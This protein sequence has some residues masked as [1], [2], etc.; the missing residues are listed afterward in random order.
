M[1]GDGQLFFHRVHR[2][3]FGFSDSYPIVAFIEACANVECFSQRAGFIPCCGRYS[4][5][6]FWHVY[7]G[8]FSRCV[9]NGDFSALRA[10][11]GDAGL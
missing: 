11:A 8:E 4:G 2:L 3:Y 7:I 10:F 9:N 5:D 1:D 6:W